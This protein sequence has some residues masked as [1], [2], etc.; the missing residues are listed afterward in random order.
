M[1]AFS[2]GREK[3]GRKLAIFPPAHFNTFIQIGHHL[4]A[5][6]FVYA[7]NDSGSAAAAKWIEDPVERLRLVVNLPGWLVCRRCEIV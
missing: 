4:I 7:W 5:E 6:L 3:A 2:A 1:Q